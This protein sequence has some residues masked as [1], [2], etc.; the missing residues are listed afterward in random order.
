MKL[1]LEAVRP[2]NSKNQSLAL[3]TWNSHKPKLAEWE[4]EAKTNSLERPS[5]KKRKE[6]KYIQKKWE[7]GNKRGLRGRR[8]KRRKQRRGEGIH[9]LEKKDILARHGDAS[10]RQQPWWKAGVEETGKSSC[11]PPANV[12]L[13]PL[14]DSSLFPLNV[15]GRGGEKD[16]S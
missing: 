14:S 7:R 10:Q 15:R 5:G 16:L 2:R 9:Y 13:F 1:A 11:R 6:K 4:W 8:E 3:A 12:M